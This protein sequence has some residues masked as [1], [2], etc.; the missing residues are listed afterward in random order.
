MHADV[1]YSA[2][3]IRHAAQLPLDKG[4]VHVKLKQGVLQL[5]PLVLGVAGGSLAGRITVDVNLVPAA[6]DTRFD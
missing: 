5:E 4:S 3:D 1:I 6:F 2:L